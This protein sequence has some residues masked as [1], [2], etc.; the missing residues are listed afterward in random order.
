[1]SQP[2]PAWVSLLPPNPWQPQY[3]FEAYLRQASPVGQER[4]SGATHLATDELSAPIG[5]EVRAILN[6]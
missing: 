2:S 1:M 4:M 6:T 5:Y 3:S